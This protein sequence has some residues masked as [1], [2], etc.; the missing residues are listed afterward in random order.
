MCGLER[1]NLPVDFQWLKNDIVI[2]KGS[3]YDILS[4]SSVSVLTVKNVT[5]KSSG[6]YTCSARNSVGVDLFTAELLVRGPPRWQT[7]PRDTAVSLGSP[8]QLYCDAYGYP[9][10]G[11][12]WTKD[13]HISTRENEQFDERRWR[14]FLNGTLIIDETTYEDGG[15]YT[16]TISNG[17]GQKLEKTVYV[18]IRGFA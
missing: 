12:H 2:T 13:G 17:M 16:C 4:S 18:N 10:P 11:V 1:G 5:V 14:I 15:K 8:L 3:L 9:T 6:N 7:I